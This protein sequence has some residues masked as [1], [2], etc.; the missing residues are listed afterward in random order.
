MKVKHVL[1]PLI[2]SFLFAAQT[3]GSNDSRVSL[4]EKAAI[5][6]LNFSAGDSAGLNKLRDGFTPQGWDAYMK[7]LQPY[8]DAKGAPTFN[9]AFVPAGDF[10][11]VSQDDS[12]VFIKVPGTLTQSSGG[13]RT[14]YRLRLEVKAI[15]NPPKIDSL[16]QITC[17][18]PEAA[19]YCM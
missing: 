13:S 3:L 16:K 4:T 6:A 8:L 12:G 9:S 7:T 1:V 14:T 15:G 2:L 19:N 18:K 10:V 17:G 5:D 11:V